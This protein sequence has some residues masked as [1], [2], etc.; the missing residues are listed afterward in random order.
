MN[1]AYVAY[2]VALVLFGTNGIVASQIDLTSSEIVLS[3]TLIGAVFLAIAFAA[4]RRKPTFFRAGRQ[5]LY[6]M[7]SGVA[8][9]LSWMFLFE[10]YRQIGVSVATLVYYCGPVIVMALSPVVFKERITLA[11][12]AGFLAVLVGM[13]CVNGI[14]SFTGGMSW[15]LMCGIL[16][17]ATYAVMVIANKKASRITGLENSLWQLVFACIAVMIFT[18]ATHEGAFSI[19]ATSIAPMLFLGVVNTGL[20]CFLY[21]SSI[22][23]LSA[24]AV[25]IWGYLEPL[26]A[27]A[28]SAMF[29]G[30]QLAVVQIVGAVLILGGAAFGSLYGNRKQTNFSR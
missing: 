29:L 5:S 13:V 16:S 2:I 8:M 3:R 21:F 23:K 30:E 28:F 6:L 27:L 11:M 12:A 19:P 24:Q 15:G 10:A 9:G 25:S 20:G 26:S 1:K 22:K 17:A 4:G 7:I 18:L 14:E